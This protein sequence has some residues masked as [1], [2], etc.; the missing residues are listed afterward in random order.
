M[1]SVIYE[2]KE[3]ETETFKA[4]I[5]LCKEQNDKTDTSQG[6]IYLFTYKTII[7]TSKLIRT[8]AFL[9][10]IISRQ[11]GNNIANLCTT[12]TNRLNHNYQY[13]TNSYPFKENGEAG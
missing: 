2:E 5:Q 1:L 12:L 8:A 11:L 7:K 9:C 6:S 13:P 3:K 10:S 4:I